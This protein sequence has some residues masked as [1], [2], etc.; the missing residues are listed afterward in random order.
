MRTILTACA[1][2]TG[3]AIAQETPK[4][5]ATAPP[6]GSIRGTVTSTS[7][8]AP[9]READIYIDR[10][11]K[12]EVHAVTDQQGRY[13]LLGVTPGQHRVN[14]TA[15]DPNGRSFGPSASRLV[16]VAPG[17]DLPAVDFRLVIP[18]RIT[19]K[20]V[21]QNNEP[22]TGIPVYLVARE[23]SFGKLRAFFAGAGTTDDEGQYDIGRVTPGRSYYVLATTRAR[24]PALSEAPLDPKLRRPAIVPTYYPNGR[25]LEGG[26]P[27]VLRGGERREGI[28]IRMVRSPSFCITGVL[29]GLA[30]PAKIGF[31]IAET[32]PTSGRSGNGAMYTLTPGGNSGPDGKIRICDLHPGDYELVVMEFDKGGRSA[33]E[34]FASTMVTIGDRD[35]A[36]VHL[37]MRPPIPVPGEVVFDGPAPDQPLTAQLRLFA[38]SITRTIRGE[39]MAPI[40]GEFTLEKL[41]MDEFS[42]EVTAVP[43]GIYVKD[44]TYGER[45]ILHGTLR[46]GSAMGTGGLRV[47]LGRDGG[48]VSARVTDNDGNPAADVT[49]VVMPAAADSEGVFAASLATGKTD[50]NGN[51]SSP[52][53]GPG[54]YLAL[55]IKDPFDRSPETIAKL[56]KSRNHASDVEIA[57]QGKVSVTLAVRGLE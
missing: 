39:T 36:N 31:Q 50:Q 49:V 48:T 15:R 3:L 14:V 13:T 57:P 10:N 7:D 2:I 16:T 42:L 46:V 23:Y 38:E 44:V 17:Q 51:W 11:S 40:P 33:L 29:D 37:A 45:S 4:K 26:Q 53:L 1:I 52:T 54:K 43:H 47:I 22:V 6:T 28:D 12:L 55:A 8:N 20:V 30:G 41:V 32:Q 21:D 9:M 27:L 18:G 24:L 56:L 19:G 5:D 25:S 34:G 35:V